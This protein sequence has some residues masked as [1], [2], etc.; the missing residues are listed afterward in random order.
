M[1]AP[2]APDSIDFVC[3]VVERV[4][5]AAKL[6][7]AAIETLE[8]G[9][10]TG[11]H[12]DLKPPD[13]RQQAVNHYPGL[14]A[15]PWHDP[16]DFEWTRRLPE[17]FEAIRDEAMALMDAGAFTLNPLSPDFAR[18]TGKWNELRL[19][20][21]GNKYL[22]NCALCPATTSLVES[23]PGATTAGSVFLASMTPGTHIRPHFGFHNARIRCHLPISVPDGCA[24]RVAEETRTWVEGE[25]LIFDDS[26]EH[27]LWNRGDRERLVLILDVWHPDLTPSEIVAIRYAGMETI[28]WGAEVFEE[29]TAS[30]RAPRAADGSGT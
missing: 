1:T 23:I 21:R 16:A 8:A 14:T 7:V 15:K 26:F 6:D 18:D 24:M 22:S 27:E 28:T 3:A 5:T 10:R 13:P 25:W 29:W 30:G 4:L 12:K 20:N 2:A 19:Y 11:R 17:S 9:L